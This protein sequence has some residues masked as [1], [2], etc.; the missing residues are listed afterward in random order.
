VTGDMRGRSARAAVAVLAVVLLAPT[1]CTESGGGG[2]SRQGPGPG[3]D[4]NRLADTGSRMDPDREGPVDLEGATRGGTVTVLSSDGLNSMDPTEAYFANTMSILTGLVTR[5][6]T[7][8]SYDAKT[9]QM[10]LVPD[11]ATDLGTPNE[12]FTRW[13]F[14]IRRGVRWENGE[15]VTPEDVRYGI[16]RSFDRATFPQGADYSNRYFLDG[17]RYK[18]PYRSG[19]AY[20]GVTVDGRTL[21]ITTS[22][23][24][25]DLPYWAASP[26]MGPV[27]RGNDS[28]GAYR[29]HPW[30]TGPYMFDEYTPEKSLTLVRNPHWDPATDPARTQ[31]PDRYVFDFQTDSTK[32]DQILLR[33]D[34]KGRTTMTYDN[35]EASDFRE[36]QQ[37]HPDRLVLGGVPLT[38]YW[39]PDYRKVT[40]KRVRQ[41]LAWAY[42]YKDAALAGGYIEGVTR[43]W[44]TNLMP[45]GM[46]GRTEYN[47]LPGHRPGT[48]DTNRARALLE[49]SDAV[50]FKVSWLYPTDDPAAVKAKDVVAR[51]LRAAGF[52]A[53][54]VATTVAQM[55]A[56][57]EDPDNDKINIRSGGW[58]SDWPS[59]GSWFPPLLH[60]TDLAEQGVGSNYAV[61]SEPDVDRR[62]EDILTMPME[63]QPAAWNRLDRYVATKYFPLIV[64]GYGGTAMAHGSDIAGFKA[65]TTS[66][67]PTWKGIW[68]R[69]EAAE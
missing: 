30:S 61:F 57:R 6:L 2:G 11:L 24:F 32:I 42:P 66:G 15:E 37:D 20:T 49:A 52:R 41:A 50:G 19:T 67:M 47:P 12:D 60:S 25:P 33:D 55:A 58:L 35:V 8:Y 14:T 56:E 62:I 1:G 36:F 5:S 68:V 34:G 45:P 43:I 39:A 13:R 38:T 46:P 59:G 51:S 48:T 29:L 31:Y 69:T 26:A 16:L 63:K 3:I 54:P 27:P 53:D 44:G 10:V 9:G 28:P 17:H 64:L 21:T 4:P 22:T 7:Q 40:D 65:D 23:P 18:G